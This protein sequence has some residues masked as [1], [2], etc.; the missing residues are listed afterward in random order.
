MDK[1]LNYKR[2]RENQMDIYREK[3]RKKKKEG[4]RERN[5]RIF[6]RANTY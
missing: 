6:F 5:G 1:Y 3:E 4:R 2:E